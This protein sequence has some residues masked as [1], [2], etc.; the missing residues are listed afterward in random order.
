MSQQDLG[1]A[2]HRVVYSDPPISLIRQEVRPWVEGQCPDLSPQPLVQ[3]YSL[4]KMV[5]S[6]EAEWH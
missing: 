2:G 4:G 6:G 1:G 3:N 5:S